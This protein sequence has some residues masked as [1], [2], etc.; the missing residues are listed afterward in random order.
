VQSF[1][2]GLR[3]A[4]EQPDSFLSHFLA[5]DHFRLVAAEVEHWLGPEAIIRNGG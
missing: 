1:A 5:R 2:G 3:K 4:I